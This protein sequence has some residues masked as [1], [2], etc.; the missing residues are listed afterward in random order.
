[1]RSPIPIPT[2]PAATEAPRGRYG[3]RAVSIRTTIATEMTMIAAPIS[4]VVVI[5]SDVGELPLAGVVVVIGSDVG[6]LPFAGTGDATGKLGTSWVTNF[7]RGD[8]REARG[9]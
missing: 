6:E 5:G 8:E 1:M 7:P 2:L 9:K 3:P 4:V